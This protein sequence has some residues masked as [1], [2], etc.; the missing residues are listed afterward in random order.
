MNPEF[1][2]RGYLL[3]NLYSPP[4]N[5]LK[6]KLL[7]LFSRKFLQAARFEKRFLELAIGRVFGAKLFEPGAKKYLNI[8]PGPESHPAFFNLDAF[9]YL[10]LDGVSDCR[11]RLPFRDGVFQGIFTEHF[12]E[13]LDYIDEFGLFLAECHRVLAPGGTVRLVTPD[14]EKYFRS[15]VSAG[16]EPMREVRNAPE[17]FYNTRAEIINE[18]FHQGVE[19]KFIFDSETLAMRCRAAGFSRVEICGF[20][21][22]QHST[23][24]IDR[25]VRRAESLYVEATK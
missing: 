14:A 1:K 4:S 22:G 9:N 5:G 24:L 3:G 13:H 11:T 12:I 6:R 16:L 2:H 7:A 17:G 20:R 15:Y 25:E 18:L 21:Q 23:L 10:G 8:A 19:H